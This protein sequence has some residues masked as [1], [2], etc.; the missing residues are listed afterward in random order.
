MGSIT[1]STRSSVT[2]K[3]F[4]ARSATVFSD[5]RQALL[6]LLL[7]PA[8]RRA[9]FLGL[10]TG[11]TAASAA[12]DA[13]LEVDAVELLQEV[14]DASA[15][16]RSKVEDGRVGHVNPIQADARPER[17]GGELLAIIIVISRRNSS[18]SAWLRLVT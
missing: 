5:A 1:R 18:C 2:R 16:F 8:P 7:H 12:S 4:S 14:I 15:Y 10:G 3:S 17:A 6:P 11:V 13:T 9:L